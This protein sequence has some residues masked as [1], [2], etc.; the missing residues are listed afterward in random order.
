MKISKLEKALGGIKD[1][2]GLPDALVVI[3]SKE[4]HIAI[5]EAKRLGIPV[6]AIV[7]SNSSPDDVDYVIP[8]NDDAVKSIRFYLNQFADAV[9]NAKQAA[10]LAKEKVAEVSEKEA[11]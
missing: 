4:E 3:D 2:G 7:D 1:M 10:N 6:V 9:I 11:E 5:E 8:G